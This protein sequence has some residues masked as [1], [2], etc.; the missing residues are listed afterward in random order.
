MGDA[1][2]FKIVWSDRAIADL[3]ELCAYI[4]SDNPEAAYKTGRGILEHVRTLATFP[5]IGPTYPRGNQDHAREIIYRPYR[6]FYEVNEEA[7]AVN[8]L[9]VRHGARREPKL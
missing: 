2:E 3:E 7:R 6:I 8:I 5:F 4:A 9:H 1:V